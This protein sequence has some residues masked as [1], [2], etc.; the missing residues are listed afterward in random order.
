MNRYPLVLI[1]PRQSEGITTI[2][3]GTIQEVVIPLAQETA[4]YNLLTTTLE[5][6][7]LHLTAVRSEVLSSVQHLSRIISDSA[8]PASAASKFHPHSP[9]TDNA[10]SVRV[11]VSGLKVIFLVSLSL[12]PS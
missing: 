12:V 2:S 3:Q 9:L 8:H 5:S 11:K 6:V 7:S 4:F 1:F 10:G